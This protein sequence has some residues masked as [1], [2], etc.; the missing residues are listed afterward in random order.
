MT[1][2]QIRCLTAGVLALLGLYCAWRLELTNSIAHFIPSRHQAE[3]V[4]LSFELV[5]SPLARRMMLSIEG[6]DARSAARELASFLR[7]HPEVSWV[8]AGADE[9]FLRG[10]YELYFERRMF[11]I[12]SSPTQQIP[13]MFEPA[14]LDERADRLLERLSRPGSML[15]ARA[16]PADPLGLFDRIT[17]R[18]LAFSPRFAVA[19]QA[20]DLA[21]IMLGLRSSPFDSSRQSPLLDDIEAEFSRLNARRADALVL[22]ESGVN[23]FAVASERSVRSDID[24]I[25]LLSISVVCS[26]FLLVFRSLRHLAIAIVTPLAGFAVAMSVAVSLPGPVHGVTLGFGFILLGVAIDYAIHLMTHQSLAPPSTPPRVTLAEIRPS[27]LLSGLTTTLAFCVLALSDFPG[28]GEMGRFAAIGIPVSLAATFAVV[29]AFLGETGSPSAVQLALASAA[30]RFVDWLAERPRS[31]ALVLGI[32]ALVSAAGLPRLHWDDDPAALL[33]MDEQLRSESERVRDRVSDFDGGRFVVGL[34]ASSEAALQLND[35]IARR[36][37]E[38]V[39]SGELEGIGSLHSFL[40]SESLQRE[41]LATLRAV[42]DL[43]ARIEASFTSRGFRPGTFRPFVADVASPHAGPLL[44]EHVRS[45]PLARV[46]DAL[47]ELDGR[48]AVVTFLRGVRNGESIRAAIGELP[49]AH[50]VDQKQIVAGVYEGFRR[51]TVRMV[52]IGAVCVFL[53]LLIRYR[54]FSLG[55]LAFLPSALGALA[56]LGW[57]GLLNLPV[58]VVSAVSLLV[59]LG[60]GV[61]YGIFAVDAARSPERSGATLSSLL[62]SCLTSVFVFGVLALS[63]QPALRAIGLTTGIGILVALALSPISLVLARPS[64]GSATPLLPRE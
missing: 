26:L 36:L 7:S 1:D 52:S 2:A 33:I 16:A 12:S 38:L 61:D 60:M 34:A 30:V 56:T 23:R 62:L 9:N 40:W 48:W 28:L 32:F 47:V 21:F 13:E 54:S 4:E 27:L 14:A 25:S 22:E 50:Y 63:S 35:E 55:F 29:P 6:P 58:N 59:V 45:S 41:N 24:F 51:S 17:Q 3:L 46:L 37:A 20:D 53:I 39:A 64:R 19:A 11:L 57:F 49:G 42:P 44:P 10:I 15:E 43:G 18:L 31:I 5:D 8:E